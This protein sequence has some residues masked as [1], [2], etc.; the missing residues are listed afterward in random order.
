MRHPNIDILKS[1][2]ENCLPDLDVCVSAALELYMEERVPEFNPALVKR[3]LVI[4]SGNAALAGRILFEDHD[5]VFAD[6]SSYEEQIEAH[7]EIENAV[8]ISASGGKHATVIAKDLSK[9]KKNL[10]LLTNNP[11]A[12]ARE[13]VPD[14]QEFLFPK[15]REPYTYNTSTYMGMILSSTGETPAHIYEHIQKEIPPIVPENLGTY[16]SFFL[17]LPPREFSVAGMLLTKFDEL[18]GARVM[19]R[20]FTVEQAKHGKTIVSSDKEL[21]ISFGT[22]NELFGNPE[23]RL[24]IPL[25]RMSGH[26]AMMAIGYYIIGQIQKQHPPYFKD[27]IE[28]YTKQATSVF[29]QDIG[30]IVD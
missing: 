12:P 9:R 8:L 13:F 3:P 6:E 5:A 18:F 14:A 17:I 21:F 1:F 4:G 16:T 2:D 10:W 24:H 7:P 28:T 19:G 11:K 20:V 26:A 23:S 22:P 30:L 25:P 27:R 29:G 15:N